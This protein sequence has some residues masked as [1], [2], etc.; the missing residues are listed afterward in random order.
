MFNQKAPAPAPQPFFDRED[1][2]NPI[3]KESHD[4]KTN[5]KY[6][7]AWECLKYRPKGQQSAQQASNPQF[8]SQTQTRAEL[9]APPFKLE[10][11]YSQQHVPSTG[12]QAEMKT[13]EPRV[14]PIK[15]YLQLR[16]QINHQNHAKAH[17]QQ[18]LQL[19]KGQPGAIKGH[20][21]LYKY[22][23]YTDILLEVIHKASH[24]ERWDVLNDPKYLDDV[25]GQ[26]PENDRLAVCGALMES[27]MKYSN[28]SDSTEHTSTF[29]SHYIIQNKQG[30]LPNGFRASMNCWEF[31]MYAQLKAGISKPDTIRSIYEKARW[32]NQKIFGQLGYTQDL[33]Q[34]NN[35][36]LQ[37][38]TLVFYS[39]YN[40]QDYSQKIVHVAISLG[41]KDIV[42][43][44][45]IG[46]SLIQNVSRIKITDIFRDP[47]QY[48]G[49]R[50]QYLSP[51]AKSDLFLN[52]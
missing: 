36:D 5:T 41:G 39:V 38:G 17:R 32:N 9:P 29:H 51:K 12:Q 26:M 45:E 33:P 37:I 3:Q 21:D 24:K 7:Q 28:P 42:S 10:S 47:L 31:L 4:C 20:L 30:Q 27:S 6:A 1:A 18:Y 50:I 25:L 14:I 11:S 13:L 16:E 35:G 40:P 23:P 52:Q 8:L 22:Y 48:P 46:S 44:H 19:K 34:Y 15:D 2:L 43:M 49:R